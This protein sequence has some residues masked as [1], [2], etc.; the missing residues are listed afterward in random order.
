MT[1]GFTTN[2]FTTSEHQLKTDGTFEKREVHSKTVVTENTTS[3]D[4]TKSSSECGRVSPIEIRC[5]GQNLMEDLSRTSSSSDV[6]D[7]RDSKEDNK[8]AKEQ[9]EAVEVEYKE[10]VKKKGDLAL[11]EVVKQRNVPLLRRAVEKKVNI[12]T[13][14]RMHGR[15]PLIGA[16]KIG[17]KKMIKVLLEANADIEGKDLLGI[18]PLI[19]AVQNGSP[20]VVK[21]LLDRKANP[22]IT[23]LDRKSPLIWAAETGNK[24]IVRALLEAGA[25]VT[26]EDDYRK[27]ALER[28]MEGNHSQI[29]SL[30]ENEMSK[31]SAEK[32]EEEESEQKVKEERKEDKKGG[33][34]KAREDEKKPTFDQLTDGSFR[35]GESKKG[36]LKP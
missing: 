29:V 10:I 8:T 7:R 20:K 35:A 6:K 11:H 16:V 33:G 4:G 31:L 9:Q 36:D 30:L 14:E 32:T 15:T 18:T 5:S 13:R 23:D 2:G 27:T 17:H 12:E 21:L 24:E 19:H 1:D 22:E 3:N 25:N 34:E 26:V 28:A